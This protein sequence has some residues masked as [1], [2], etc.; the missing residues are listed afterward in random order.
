MLRVFC[1]FILLLTSAPS[2]AA[3]VIQQYINN[4]QIVGE[5]RL[6]FFAWDVYDA[7]LFAEN[8]TW[9]PE[10]PFALRLS[11][12]RDI[13]AKKIV[14]QSIKEI[15]K[16]GFNDEIRLA[17]WHSQMSDI[18][19]MV[20]DGTELIGIMKDDNHSVFYNGEIYLGVIKDP[21][22]SHYFFNIWLG[23]ETSVADLRQN[24][25]GQR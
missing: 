8:G 14:D 11:Y 20:S 1:A 6:K 16:Q 7:T 18:F 9:N 15:R 25:I 10:Q 5:G 19:P 2:Q 24:L 23:E 22:F 13:D 12:L 17:S 4:A 21:E 3:D